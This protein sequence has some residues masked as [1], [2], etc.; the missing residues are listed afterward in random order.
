MMI[1]IEE[2]TKVRLK[3]GVVAVVME[4]FEEGAA[5]LVEVETK[6]NSW[7]TSTVERSEIVAVLNET[8][9]RLEV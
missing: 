6:L 9:T 3:S 5:F 1:A 2:F 4:I 8:V 7:E